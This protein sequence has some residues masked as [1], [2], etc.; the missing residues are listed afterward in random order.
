MTELK[1]SAI[2]VAHNEEGQLADCQDRWSRA[3]QPRRRLLVLRRGPKAGTWRRIE[4]EQARKLTDPML[5][6]VALC[7][8][9]TFLHAQ[10][11]SEP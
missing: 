6:G 7:H 11:P 5:A 2:L 8:D 10:Q 1:L 3:N 9:L 4:V